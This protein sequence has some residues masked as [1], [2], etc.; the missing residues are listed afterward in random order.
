MRR[1]TSLMDWPDVLRPCRPYRTFSARS[2][3]GPYAARRAFAIVD[4]HPR[5]LHKCPLAVH[6]HSELFAL[7]AHSAPTLRTSLERARRHCR[8]QFPRRGW[9]RV[10]CH[11][12]QRPG[13][14][15]AVGEDGLPEVPPVIQKAHAL[16]ATQQRRTDGHHATL[17]SGDAARWHLPFAFKSGDHHLEKYVFFIRNAGGRFS[18]RPFRGVT[19]RGPCVC[20]MRLDFPAPF[21]STGP[22]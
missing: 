4:A 1:S 15:T 3:Q 13:R 6:D 17:N 22:C 18:W 10:S 16:L 19:E 12:H 5:A 2:W 8:A 7:R 20:G 9:S 14:A 21:G 11:P